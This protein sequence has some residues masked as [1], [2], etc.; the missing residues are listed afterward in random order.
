MEAPRLNYECHNEPDYDMLF[1]NYRRFYLNIQTKALR[2]HV[3]QQSTKYLGSGC[4]V[5]KSSILLEHT[6]VL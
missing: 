6:V 3:L 2:R 1:D 4:D 5:R